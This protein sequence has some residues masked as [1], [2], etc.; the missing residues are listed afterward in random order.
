MSPHGLDVRL[1][2]D[3]NFQK[4]ADEMMAGHSGAVVLMNAGT[5]E[6]LAMASSPSF[7]AN[8]LNEIGPQLNKDPGKPL[9]NRAVQGVYP[10]GTLLEPFAKA[11]PANNQRSGA[12]KQKVYDAFGFMTSPQLQFQTADPV[13]TSD[14]EGI[15]VSPLQAA[16]A[17][18]SLSNHGIVPAPRIAISV[19]TPQERWVVLPALGK[20]FE[21]VTSAQAEQAATANIEDGKNYWSHI[22][23]ATG[24]EGPVTWFVAG[25]PPNWQA[26]PLAVV[27]LLE[28]DNERQAQWIGQELLMDAMNP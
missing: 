28:E 23:R 6:I 16:L 8:H 1:S 26:S 13:M 4:R 14:G 27:V 19:D 24:K 9:I 15:H 18:A 22:G 11:L 21:A 25:T 2:L 7:N 10:T 20:S 3:L 12:E 17:A 5:G